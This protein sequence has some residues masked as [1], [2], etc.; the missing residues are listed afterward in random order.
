[1]GFRSGDIEDLVNWYGDDDDM[2]G[3]TEDDDGFEMGID[4]E[5]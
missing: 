2:I 3:I 1:M 5:V 4:E